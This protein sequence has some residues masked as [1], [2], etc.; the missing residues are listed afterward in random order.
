MAT[1]VDLLVHVTHEAGVKLGGI[2]AVLDGLLGAKAYQEAIGRSI[3]VGPYNRY[4]QG[5][6]ER[7]FDPRN[8][9]KLRY[10]ADLGINLLAPELSA[11]FHA[12]EGNC[13]A[14]YGIDLR[15]G[16]DW[17]GKFTCPQ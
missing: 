6:M 13:I 16:K 10:A 15:T 11:Q 14:V 7:L 4:N 1:T 5:E 8:G 17:P 3:I 9:L 12:I 2:G